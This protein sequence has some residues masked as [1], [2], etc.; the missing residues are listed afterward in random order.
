[1]TVS[2]IGNLR[3]LTAA[4]HG[5]SS[6]GITSSSGVFVAGMH[7]SP[8]GSRLSVAITTTS[9]RSAEGESEGSKA[10]T[11]KFQ[12]KPSLNHPPTEQRCRGQVAV[13]QKAS[14]KRTTGV[15]HIRALYIFLQHARH[16]LYTRIDQTAASSGSSWTRRATPRA[17]PRRAPLLPP[18]LQLRSE[19]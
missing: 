12:N 2:W 13:A 3:G 17:T 4:H 18:R 1:M 6:V 8:K 11:H 15:M 9:K 10:L 16:L 14:E 7:S 5:D 19:N